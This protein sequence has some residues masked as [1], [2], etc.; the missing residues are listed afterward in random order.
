[1]ATDDTG[2]EVAAEAGIDTETGVGKETGWKVGAMTEAEIEWE[3]EVGHMAV[4]WA[5]DVQ[6]VKEGTVIAKE[7]T[8]IASESV[9]EVETETERVAGNGEGE[10]VASGTLQVG[11]DLASQT[12]GK[13]EES[14]TIR[15]VGL[16]E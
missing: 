15:T 6:A 12:D 5:P 13:V 11:G 8:V 7:G 1:M 9:V 2:I 10:M 14:V 3:M 4:A 16:Q